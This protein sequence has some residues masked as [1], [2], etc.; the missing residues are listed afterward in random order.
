MLVGRVQRKTNIRFENMDDFESY[1]NAIDNDYDSEDVTFTCYV[2]KLNTLQFKVVK[3]FAYAKGTNYRKDIVEYCGQ[4]CYTPTS[5]MCFIKCINYFTQKDY[6]EDVF[7]FIR[8][9]K[10]RSGVMTY[11]RVQPFCRKDNFD[12]GYFIGNEIWRRTI[13]QRY[14]ALKIHDKHFCLIW[15]SSGNIFIQV[16]E[17]E[18]KPNF[19]IVDNVISD[20]HVKGYNKSEYK[21]KKVQFPL[22]NIVV[23]GLE[24]FNEI[25]AVPHCSCKYKPSKVAGKYNRDII[26]KEYQKSLNDCV[27]FKRT[28]CIS[29]MLDHALSFK[30]EPKRSKRRLLNTIYK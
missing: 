19:K 17:N 7:T 6:T 28:D 2:D 22:T 23:Y 4:N 12:I 10:N 15:K 24:T 8:S 29:E 20:K 16:I 3:R 5:G 26:E 18:V 9:E 1:I 14:I 25:R 27:S 30:G 13:T 21:P 11:A